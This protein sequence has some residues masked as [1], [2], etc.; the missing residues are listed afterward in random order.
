MNARCALAVM[1]FL[2]SASAF[3]Q[4]RSVA[5]LREVKPEPSAALEASLR[6]MLGRLDVNLDPSAGDG[7]VP[8]LAVIDV[9]FSTGQIV[10][11][12]PSR[13]VTIRRTVPREVSGE[14]ATE[15]AAT[16]IASS[17]DVLLHTDPPRQ[18]I[19]VEVPGQVFVQSE[20]HARPKLSPVG[21]DLGVG[22]GAKL[23]GGSSTVDFGGSVHA[24]LSIPLGTQLPGVL[25]AVTFQPGFDLEGDTVTLRGSLLSLRL[26]V[27]LEMIRWKYGRLEAGAGGGL[28][29]FAF[30]PLQR[31]GEL[32]RQA[33]TRFAV[34]P[35]VSGLIT[36]RLPVGDTVHLFASVL[37][38]GDLRPPRMMMGAPTPDMN[39]P[40]PWTVR[41]SLQL[42]VSFAPLRARE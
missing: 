6:E 19:K 14:V 5:V 42:G 3:A 34:A 12:S 27:Q 21:L 24:L 13:V 32:F 26:F 31:E 41:P 25:A 39:D 22:L 37:V 16:L 28:D 35:I 23:L 7:G 18:P 10:V 36:Y 20:P 15:T 9:D 29:R 17:I 2:T 11:D 30:T 33:G 38:D 1:M 4:G 40:R 8:A